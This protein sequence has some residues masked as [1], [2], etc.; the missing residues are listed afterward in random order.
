METNTSAST[1]RDAVKQE[2]RDLPAW[3]YLLIM[4]AG[5]GTIV[6]LATSDWNTYRI[7]DGYGWVEHDHDTPVW[8]Q[9]EW[10]AGEYRIC[11]MPGPVWG[12]LPTYAYLL[13]GKGGGLTATQS[14]SSVKV[15]SGRRCLRFS[16][17]SNFNSSSAS[18]SS[19]S[20]RWLFSTRQP[21]F[22]SVNCLHFA[23]ATSISRIWS[24]TS[25]DRSG[26]RFWA[27]ARQKRQPNL[28]PWTVIWR[29]TFCA[30]V[31]RACTRQTITTSS[32]ARP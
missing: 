19:E 8:I 2:P 1:E 6:S 26:I 7:L 22:G 16:N 23:G 32:L 3:A 27:T 30:G 15:R 12:E 28:S 10:L 9:G 21:D 25:R 24:L 5:I 14:S 29:R 17:F 31:A 11:Q 18:C 13:C 20:A 4:L